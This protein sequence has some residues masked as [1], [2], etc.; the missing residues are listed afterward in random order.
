MA[1]APDKPDPDVVFAQ[2]KAI[3]KLRLQL[4]GYLRSVLTDPDI[5]EDKKKEVYTEVSQRMEKTAK[6]GAELFQLLPEKG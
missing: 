2:L 3:V 5:S 1:A 6:Q 4:V